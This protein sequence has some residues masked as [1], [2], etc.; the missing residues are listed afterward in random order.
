MSVKK[1]PMCNGKGETVGPRVAEYKKCRTCRGTGIVSICDF[2]GGT[3]RYTPSGL[4]NSS[5]K[6]THC[7]GKGY[8]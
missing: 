6:C 7:D 3:G 8:D 5:R 2:C 4:F 1:C